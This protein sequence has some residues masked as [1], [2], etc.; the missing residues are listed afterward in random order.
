MEEFRTKVRRDGVASGARHSSNSEQVV[1]R[2]LRRRNSETDIRSAATGFQVQPTPR[3]GGARGGNSWPGVMGIALSWL[4]A[5]FDR[6][7]EFPPLLPPSLFSTMIVG[8]HHGNGWLNDPVEMRRI[9]KWK[10]W[11]IL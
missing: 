3:A 5:L 2:I 10:R 7:V 9:R 4:N 6:S 8:F 11:C 1:I